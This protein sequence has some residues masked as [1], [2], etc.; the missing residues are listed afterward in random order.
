MSSSIIKYK[1]IA[2]AADDDNYA[3]DYERKCDKLNDIFLKESDPKLIN[4]TNTHT[5]TTT[6]ITTTNTNTKSLINQDII[7][8]ST[9]PMLAVDYHNNLHRFNSISPEKSILV[10]L[11]GNLYDCDSVSFESEITVLL[12]SKVNVFFF[13][14]IHLA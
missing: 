6:P 5:T 13:Y 4:I 12:K 1:S 2:H 3:D 9:T 10:N 8:Y 14:L 7:A 11:V